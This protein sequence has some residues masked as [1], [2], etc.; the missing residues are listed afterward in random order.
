MHLRST[1]TG[2]YCKECQNRNTA[3]DDKDDAKCFK[4]RSQFF[5]PVCQLVLIIVI[6]C[7]FCISCKAV[8][9]VKHQRAYYQRNNQTDAICNRTVLNALLPFKSFK[10]RIRLR[11]ICKADHKRNYTYQRTD[12]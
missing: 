3:Y 4:I 7:R 12:K 8:E 6:E 5:N 1:G 11:R 2:K 9:K 10:D